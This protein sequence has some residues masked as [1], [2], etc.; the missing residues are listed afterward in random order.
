MLII[1]MHNNKEYLEELKILAKEAKIEDFLI[2]EDET[3]G[4][5]S[6]GATSDVVFSQSSM[7]NVYNKSFLAIIEDHK[8]GRQFLQMIEDDNNLQRSNW[9]Q[10]GFICVTPFNRI[11]NLQMSKFFNKKGGEDGNSKLF[12]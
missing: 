11:K 3:L 2:V 10:E 12:Q 4:T 7:I 6:K 1:V 9:D 5:L 8:K